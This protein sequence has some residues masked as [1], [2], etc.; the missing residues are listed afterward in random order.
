VRFSRVG[1]LWLE[2]GVALVDSDEEALVARTG[3]Y[4]ESTSEVRSSPVRARDS[5][6]DSAGGKR[7]ARVVVREG[8]AGDGG[9][10]SRLGTGDR[11]KHS[12]MRRSGRGVG[13]GGFRGGGTESLTHEAHVTTSEQKKWQ[14]EDCA[15]PFSHPNP[16]C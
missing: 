2:V 16:V 7:A 12:T 8:G 3:L 9:I 15:A 14:Q 1:G 11:I 4:R 13:N 6:G 5:V 10:G